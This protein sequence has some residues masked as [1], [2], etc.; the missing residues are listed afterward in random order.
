VRV[1]VLDKGFPVVGA[2]ALRLPP[3]GRDG[4]LAGCRAGR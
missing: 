2:G 1:L 4:D 3:A